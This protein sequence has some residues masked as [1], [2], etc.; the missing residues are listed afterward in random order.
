MKT[1]NELFIYG[2]HP[3]LL[4]LK[5]NKRKIYKIYTSNI[6]EL[7]EY[8]KKEKIKIQ[9]NLIEFKNNNEI[10]KIAKDDINHQ[11]YL[12]VVSNHFNYDFDDFIEKECKD[13]NNLPKLLILDQLTDPHNIGAIMRSAVAFGVKYIITTERN[14]PKDSGIIVKSSAGMS[15]MIDIIEVV[16][17]NRALEELKKVGYFV[18]G[19]AGEAKTNL[20]SIK[21]SKNLCV[22]VGNEGNGIRP[23]VKKNCDILTK[24]EMDECVESLN[25]S[26]ATAIAIYQLWG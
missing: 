24:I 22:V 3:V 12:A 14:T 13:K 25:V 8:L 11:G 17:L 20:K 21:D 4:A 9:S 1:N 10:K 6:K 5:H 16:N 26:V 19:M 15:E 2:K 7:E 23:L 18:V